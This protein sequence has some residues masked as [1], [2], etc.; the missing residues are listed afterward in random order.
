MRNAAITFGPTWLTRLW[1]RNALVRGVDRAESLVAV[2]LLLLVLG[3]VAVAGAIGTSVYDQKSQQYGHEAQQSR[4]LTATAT[5]D[6]TVVPYPNSVTHVVTA[7]WNAAGTTHTDSFPFSRRVR[8]GENITI[9]VG[10]DGRR[11]L[12]PPPPSQ[13]ATVA[14][15]IAILAWLTAFDAALLIMYAVHWRF[16]RIRYRRWDHEL[17]GTRGRWPA[18]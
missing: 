17:A 15:S 3:F 6:S 14:T 2:I 12:R 5:E 4:P 11:V 7:R 16:D 13:A 9:W 8:A 1:S 18:R 10:P